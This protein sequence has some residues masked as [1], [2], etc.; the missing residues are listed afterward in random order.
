MSNM[1][2]PAIAVITSSPDMKRESSLNI[3][4]FL[5]IYNWQDVLS[6]RMIDR[7]LLEDNETL[8]NIFKFIIKTGL[9]NALKNPMFNELK[10]PAVMD[11]VDIDFIHLGVVAIGAVHETNAEIIIE[12]ENYIY[13]ELKLVELIKELTGLSLDAFNIHDMYLYCYNNES[14][15]TPHSDFIENAELYKRLRG[16]K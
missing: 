7:E 1:V 11:G 3:K 12:D 6:A 2:G 16:E 5:D 8:N 15:I 9:R 4:G 14:S 10:Y 13:F